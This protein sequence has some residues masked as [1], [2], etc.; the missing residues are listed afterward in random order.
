MERFLG[1]L[2]FGQKALLLFMLDG[3]VLVKKHIDS[4]E[5]PYLNDGCLYYHQK[6]VKSVNKKYLAFE[7]SGAAGLFFVGKGRRINAVAVNG[8]VLEINSETGEVIQEFKVSK[9]PISSVAHSTGLYPTYVLNFF[10]TLNTF[11]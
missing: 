3:E 7:C 8:L 6:G 4:N 9:K 1:M 2:F 10:F 5:R 11:I